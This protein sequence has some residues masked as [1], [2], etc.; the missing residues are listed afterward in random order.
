VSHTRVAVVQIDFHPAALVDRHSP[1]EDPLFQLTG[2]SSLLPASGLVPEQ[3]VEPFKQLRARVRREHN[4][5]LMLKLRAVLERCQAWG[6]KLVLL[7]E[8]SVA[9]ELLP[10]LATIA[11]ELVVV[12]GTHAVE[13]AR[14]REGI[15]ARLGWPDAPRSGMAVAPVLHAGRLLAL[16]PKLS[17]NKYERGSLVLGDRWDPIEVELGGGPAIPGPLG[18]M[19]CLDFLF[20]ERPEDREQVG[21]RLDRVRFLAVPSYTP[22]HSVGEFAAEAWQQ[23][24]RYGRPVLWANVASDGGS[25]IFIDEGRIAELQNY[26]RGVGL[27]ERG[28]EGVIVADV[29]LGYRR[30]GGSTRYGDDSIV[31]PVAVASLVYRHHPI[32]DG[33]AAWVEDFERR[34]DT[35]NEDEA[36]D[37]VIGARTVLLEAASLPGGHARARRLR[38]LLAE[39][40]R[41]NVNEE[42]RQFTREVV[43]PGGALPLGVLRQVWARECAELVF[44][45]T[46]AHRGAGLEEVEQRLRAGGKPEVQAEWPEAGLKALR[47]TAAAIRAEVVEEQSD[48]P[49]VRERVPVSMPLVQLNLEGDGIQLVFRA[50]PGELRGPD[51]WMSFHAGSRADEPLARPRWPSPQFDRARLLWLLERARGHLGASVV[52]IDAGEHNSSV[53]VCVREGDRRV[54]L[55]AD[56]GPLA[57]WLHD[58][59]DA[60]LRVTASCCDELRFVSRDEYYAAVAA[61]L[62]RF[63]G[64]R[65]VIDRAVEFRLREL[66]RASTKIL[67]RVDD[68]DTSQV[69]LDVLE[70]WLGR[71]EQVMLVSGGFGTG[72][73]TLLAQWCQQRWERSDHGGV[74]R[75]PIL[76]DLATSEQRE[77][78]DALLLAAGRD[79][80]SLPDRAA[81]SLLLSE[82][83]LIAC[84]DGF[85]EMVTRLGFHEVPE[86]LA[87]LLEV[88]NDGGKL[89]VASRDSYFSSA[90]AIARDMQQAQTRSRTRGHVHVHL[91]PFGAAQVDDV[92]RQFIKDAARQ[93][94][95]REKIRST[96][97]LEDLV[98]T[99]MLLSMV[100]QT[101]DELDPGVRV[102]SANVYERYLD[103]V[104]AHADV[105]DPEL[106][107]PEQKRAFAEVLAAELWRSGETSL[108]WTQLHKSVMAT[109]Y[110]VL[111]TAPPEAGL[112]EIQN[113]TFFVCEGEDRFRFAHKSFLEF[114]VAKG[115]LAGLERNP[116]QV[117]DT[118]RL[119]PEVAAFVA[120]LLRV[121]GTDKDDP[122]V[123]SLQRWLVGGREGRLEASVRAA[124]NALRLLRDVAREL[125]Q[126]SG[127]VPD[128]ADLRGV[129]LPGEGLDELRLHGARFGRARLI[130]VGFR[131]TDLRGS[132]LQ[133]ADL[134]DGHF[135]EAVLDDVDFEQ[136]NLSG[137]EG[138]DCS[139]RGATFRKVEMRQANWTG[140]EW[141]DA[142][143]EHATVG[144]TILAK[145]DP[146]AG[147]LR[148]PI[149]GSR[150]VVGAEH[151]HGARSVAWSPD[152]R[153]I[154]SGSY[155]TTLCIW[156]SHDGR[157]LSTLQG[158]SSRVN[159]VAWSPDGLRIAS[160]SD[161]RSIRTWD[162]LD[163]RLLSILQC[164]DPVSSVSS[165]DWAPD[166]IHLASASGGDYAVRIWHATEER[167]IS[168]LQGHTGW[169]TSVAWAPDGTRIASAS[170]DQSVRIWC[171]NG[172]DLLFT[173]QG[174]ANS[175]NSVAWAPD[176]I[177]IA[178]A[179]SDH[180]IHIW[181]SNDGSLLST[182]QCSDPVSSVA[183]ARDG[184][185]IASTSADDTLR[186]W[187][188]SDG[189]LL[190][191][192]QG[193][194]RWG[195]SVA[196]A[197]DS[198]R[199]ASTATST[200][201]T[202]R[203][204]DANGGRLLSTLQ[205][206][207][208]AIN[209]VDWAPSGIR[210]ASA[211]VDGIIRIWH[212]NDGSLLSTLPGH[213]VAWAP[214]GVRIAAA[215]H[216]DIRIWDADDD[217]LLS[218]LHG[219]SRSIA[220]A[221]DGI[222][223][224]GA[225]RGDYTI[226]I[227]DGNDGRLISTLQGH[228][229]FVNCVAWAP[230]GFRIASASDDRTIRFWRAD[231]GLMLST[232]DGH[233]GGVRSIAW[234]PDGLRIASA[235]DDNTVRIWHADGSLTFILQGHSSRVG[236]VAWS[237]DGL[238]IAS[239]S[240]DNTVRI[241]HAD[242]GRLLSTLQG[243]SDWVLSVAWSPDGRRIASA[244]DDNSIR[245]WHAAPAT[246][247]LP[248]TQNTLCVSYSPD[249]TNFASG[250][251]DRS[252]HICDSQSLVRTASTRDHRS[253]VLALT[254]SPTGEHLASASND[255]RIRIFDAK[256]LARVHV[257]AGHTRDATNLAYSPD[258]KLLASSSG[259]HTV[260]LWNPVTGE[261][262]AIANHKDWAN[263]VAFSPDSTKLASG[264]SD[265]GIH[266][267][268]LPNL[269][270][271]LE[272]EAHAHYVN[273]IAWY[274]DG[275]RLVSSSWDKTLRI[276]DANDGRRI[277]EIIGHEAPIRGLAFA[278]DGTRFASV[279]DD[280]TL[281]IWDAETYKQLEVF[282][283]QTGLRR[284]AWSPDSAQIIAGSQAGVQ[285][286]RIEP[287]LAILQAHGD[288]SL[289]QTPSGQFYLQPKS[290]EA[291]LEVPRPDRTAVFYLPL[292]GIRMHQSRES[293][294]HALAGRPTRSLAQ[295]LG[296][297]PVGW[298]GEVRTI[299]FERPSPRQRLAIAPALDIITNPFSPD[300]AL[301][302]T[303]TLPGRRAEL[304]KVVQ[305]LRRRGVV[306]LR[307]PR[308]AGKTSLLAF[309]E[310]HLAGHR[311][312]TRSLQAGSVKTPN[313]IAIL[314]VPDLRE[315]RSPADAFWDR[316]A[317]AD[318]P[319][320]M[321]DEIAVLVEAEPQT[322]R[323]LRALGQE[324]ASLIYSGSHYD[325]VQVKQRM[326]A[327]PGSS[328][329]NDVTFVDFGPIPEPDALDFLITTAPARAPISEELARWVIDE[330]GTWPYYLQVLGYALVEE[331]TLHRRTL[332][333]MSRKGFGEFYRRVLLGEKDNYFDLRW[334]E[335]TARAH[336]I[337]RDALDRKTL[338]NSTDLTTAEKRVLR[339]EGALIRDSWA[340]DKPFLDWMRENRDM[341][342]E[343]VT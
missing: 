282:R 88:A 17:A 276:W 83:E 283:S 312:F 132:S 221:P 216:D 259:D 326:R 77:P 87:A 158:H 270:K 54:L 320:I 175:V 4:R 79:P 237:P 163:G 184:V 161:D 254:H 125:G 109:L 124:A 49:Q 98:Q 200:D 188:A 55:A 302:N 279:S 127:W 94:Q 159:S 21:P 338:P 301:R 59:V 239:A 147:S 245:I 225:S 27:L 134:R 290:A 11:P 331:Q 178:S 296:W 76:V 58:R 319:V 217:R 288:T 146:N 31:K 231:D 149:R 70:A 236:S 16:Q 233:S 29:D 291:Y 126:R 262:L 65:A 66:N 135:W 336:A 298:D 157:L 42:F 37:L 9:A 164:A 25:S 118:A 334:R 15:Y 343:E 322:L 78:I 226:R 191:A 148:P 318:S 248:D 92:I 138:H 243:H 97:D 61:L 330:C 106:F 63:E 153:Y 22:W 166:G 305:A 303:S 99:P 219:Y 198:L 307:G 210:I 257:L 341:L 181:N 130:G 189:R 136:A 185:R 169:V 113:G 280:K 329:G 183:W 310:G 74:I 47:E 143:V 321:L 156:H 62:E 1:L 292:A 8:Y 176:S 190:S 272:I 211:S 119:T 38:R 100:L 173:F 40:E 89:L 18:V 304:D 142:T 287:C 335:F 332:S 294:A 151:F 114:F 120:E 212:A 6:V 116:E 317:K 13:R 128:R 167:V 266:V 110:D 85:D 69:A 224:A 56:W 206:R 240:D 39:V 101:I 71:P 220:W 256:T 104:L 53:L 314:L 160:A 205:G 36:A 103:R 90:D 275:Q 154:V 174:H 281:R 214:D 269:D 297:A 186:I 284:V 115:L 289:V 131:G 192:L 313:D 234:A 68:G 235:S 35:I 26:P 102:G 271:L 263:C 202:I 182:L 187:H 201:D 121:R 268:S 244:S 333:R 285:I 2:P 108:N 122:A 273:G 51:H 96:Y 24:R 230:D 23:A 32:G 45:W 258:G 238:R 180:N 195:S 327:V 293:V 179:S 67:A 227:R 137:V 86:R 308:R 107:S 337:L 117:L 33:Y 255:C 20:R 265:H 306:W 315:S 300:T 50:T 139:L 7:P 249:G 260:R 84:F 204:W 155:D 340:L 48:F 112:L 218:T 168:T 111:P 133:D 339:D 222:R 253:A 75:C 286:W 46:R 196:W 73:S 316:L 277:H 123:Q 28:D 208:N 278:P 3:L 41:I 177:R 328:F 193:Y 309:L 152:G 311:V 241:W 295:T 43:L 251:D 197:L 93:A 44:E 52:G 172:G 228:F 323:W 14:Q 261:A 171:A 274:P 64:A 95:V 267:W 213:N 150:L 242:D 203:I 140:C 250:A 252:L 229:K 80:A 19:I 141:S 5:C 12:A 342:E 199:I 129:D 324:C 162:A 299:P 165:V 57:E 145:T 246:G 209:C 194:C 232:L 60:I 91:Q 72:K 10:E 144:P 325:W 215:S 105:G 207:S 82:G 247:P 223:I 30:A 170:D 81:L 34:L 264:S